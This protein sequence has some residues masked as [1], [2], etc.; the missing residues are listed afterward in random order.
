MDVMASLV[1]NLLTIT[2][3]GVLAAGVLVFAVLLL[4]RASAAAAITLQGRPSR[5]ARSVHRRGVG[6]AV[7]A[8]HARALGPEAHSVSLRLP[9]ALR[10]HR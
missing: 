9:A 6:A 2:Q 8:S 7:Q 5:N 3:I 10:R 4:T 1:I